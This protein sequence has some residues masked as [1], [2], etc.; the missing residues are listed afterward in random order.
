MEERRPAEADEE[1]LGHPPHQRPRELPGT[2]PTGA[3]PGNVLPRGPRASVHAHVRWRL[4]PETKTRLV[5]MAT[6]GGGS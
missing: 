1:R 2:L 5:D 3:R 4:T 6:L